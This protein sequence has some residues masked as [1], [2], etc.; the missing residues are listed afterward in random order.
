MNL[1]ST[2]RLLIAIFS[3]K[4]TGNLAGYSIGS[5]IYSNLTEHINQPSAARWL[6]AGIITSKVFPC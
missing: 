2:S 5:I 4:T 6:A 3:C 1:F